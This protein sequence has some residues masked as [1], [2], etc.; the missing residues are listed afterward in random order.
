MDAEQV[1]SEQTLE[2]IPSLLQQVI[3]QISTGVRVESETSPDSSLAVT[4]Y[5]DPSELT[6]LNGPQGRTARS[7]RIIARS[8]GLKAGQTVTLD[9]VPEP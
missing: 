8:V 9:F 2:N 3:Q 4:V 6:R 5:M 7:L 1:F